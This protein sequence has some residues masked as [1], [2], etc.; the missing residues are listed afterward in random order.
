M[1]AQPRHMLARD[2]L[3]K[4]PQFVAEGHTAATYG[5]TPNNPVF[6]AALQMA[7][8]EKANEPEF[9][10]NDYG[11]TYD[12]VGIKK[13]R[14]R[15]RV[16]LRGRVRGTAHGG[17]RDLNLITWACHV[18]GGANTAG[19][20]LTWADSYLDA[21]GT[22]N[23]RV[24]KGCKPLSATVTISPTDAVM[25]EIEMAAQRYYEESSLAGAQIPGAV[26]DTHDP[27]GS[28]LVFDDV[29]EFFYNNVSVPIRG[30]S[31]TCTWTHRVQ[32]SSG[33]E[34]DIFREVSARRITGTIDAFKVDRDLNEDARLGTQR[35]SYLILQ[36]GAGNDV[37]AS[38]QLSAPNFSIESIIP[39]VFG[40]GISIECM[41]NVAGA[42]AAGEIIVDG[43]RLTTR[44]AG[45]GLT[46]GQLRAALRAN[47]RAAALVRVA[48][49]AG[50]G[51]TV[52][53]LARANLAG[54][55]DND[56]KLAL[57]WLRFMPSNENLIDNTEATMESK[58]FDAD[59]IHMAVGA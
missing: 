31:V 53:T 10:D 49:A 28:P 4:P 57:P 32:D 6:G 41:R 15:N 37:R 5:V 26:M 48:A 59:G 13:V 46:A 19:E 33:S 18:P 1:P 51:D 23:Y 30:A 52:G 22:E 27:P 54:G 16:T 7:V 12:R 44:I 39:G 56:S 35:G 36:E 8:L 14:E 43:T 50:D 38:R 58:S 25:L 24:W 20:S 55:V 34:Y 40:N 42:P 29:G 2:D 9:I 45:A 11:G 21:H 17:G 47:P 3:R